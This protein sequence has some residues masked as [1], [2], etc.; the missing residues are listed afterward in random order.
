[1]NGEEGL[2]GGARLVERGR[3]RASTGAST[4][5]WGQAGNE[6]EGMRALD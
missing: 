4:G 3:E 2:T 1:M 5:G 6:R